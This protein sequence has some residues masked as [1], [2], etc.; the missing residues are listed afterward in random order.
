MSESE[1][2]CCDFLIFGVVIFCDFCDF[3]VCPLW[4]ILYVSSQSLNFDSLVLHYALQRTRDGYDFY[5]VTYIIIEIT[6]YN[7]VSDKKERENYK[8]VYTS[9]KLNLPH[10]FDTVAAFTAVQIIPSPEKPGLHEQVKLPRVLV[11]NASR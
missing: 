9:G 4:Y 8:N 3:C 6:S 1:S 10:G 2:G 11:Q 5:S 7:Y